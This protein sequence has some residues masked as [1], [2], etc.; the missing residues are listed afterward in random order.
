MGRMPIPLLLALS[1]A[2]AAPLPPAARP[3]VVGHRGARARF[4]ENT[5]PAVR[6]ALESGADGV[7]VDVRVTADDV[8]VVAHDGTLPPD[9]CRG[10]GGRRV[11]PGVA[12]RG[13]S[14]EALQRYDCGATTNPRFP[15]QVAVPGTRIPS[16]AQLLDLLAASDPR[17]GRRSLLF[18]EL[19]LDA[20]GPSLSP[21][22]EPYARLVAGLLGERDALGR[23]V[24]L[25]FDHLLLRELR[26][27]EPGL[28]TMPLV[29]SSDDAVAVGRREEAPWIGPRHDRLTPETV[30]ALHAAGVRVFAWTA[31]APREQERL[32]DLGV[33][34]IGT[35]D[36]AGLV[37][38]QAKD[39]PR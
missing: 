3:L 22:R 20:K 7:E 5:L 33:D 15:A 17:A 9:L 30:G 34:A 38:R 27:L 21:A 11:P 24:V 36:P 6:H 1:G 28:A 39:A 23:T 19:K 2:P 25:S 35:D 13:L 16:L 18:L 10:P 29:E 31:N 8:L 14:F 37:A 12:I 32:R 4:P 26:R